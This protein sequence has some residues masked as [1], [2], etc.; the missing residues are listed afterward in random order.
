M[1]PRNEIKNAVNSV[2]EK[3]IEDHVRALE[4]VRNPFVDR[5]ALAEAADYIQ[6]SFE[7]TGYNVIRHPFQLAADGCTYHNL[8]A[9]HAGDRSTDDQLLVLAHYDTVHNSPGADD[10]ASG[11]AVLLEAAAAI[12]SI[13]TIRS[14]HFAALCL[15]EAEFGRPGLVGSR[16]L[17]NLAL[18]EGYRIKGIINLESVGYAGEN[19][20]Q[21]YPDTM[22]VDGP[23]KG[24]YIAVVANSR[25]VPLAKG[26]TTSIE[27]YAI[28]LPFQTLNVPGNGESHADARRGDHA[29]FWD[30]GYPAIM[31][32][33]TGNFRNPHY[34]KETDTL[35]TLNFPFAANV[36][37]ALVACVAELAGCE[38]L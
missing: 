30:R 14:V 2:S 37:R 28:P 1:P 31:I 21:Y 25:S 26:F 8:I 20:R 16:A 18:K 12:R 24:D 6:Q 23:Q 27:D 7:A 35:D 34:H 17:A 32:T 4:G 13:P 22:N 5:S 11:V 19:T 36:C 9:T 15:E 38:D 33:D 29:P 10:N 3:R